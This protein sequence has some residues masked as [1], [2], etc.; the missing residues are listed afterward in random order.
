[1]TDHQSIAGF[2]AFEFNALATPNTD[3][4]LPRLNTMPTIVDS[5]DVVPD[6]VSGYMHGYDEPVRKFKTRRVDLPN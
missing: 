6:I 1:M 4:I 3:V 2:Q 5:F